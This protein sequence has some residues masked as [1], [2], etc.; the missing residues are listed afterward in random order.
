MAEDG[1]RRTTQSTRRSLLFPSSS[2]SFHSLLG[3]R[4]FVQPVTAY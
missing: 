4:S 2:S 1:G 3:L